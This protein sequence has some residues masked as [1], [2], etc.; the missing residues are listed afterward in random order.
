MHI[1]KERTALSEEASDLRPLTAPMSSATTTS[2]TY[3]N[4]KI[5]FLVL[6]EYL[7][8]V[9]SYICKVKWPYS[10]DQKKDLDAWC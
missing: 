8:I 9:I 1:W 5:H 7:A 3:E 4:I 10:A 6:K 2:H